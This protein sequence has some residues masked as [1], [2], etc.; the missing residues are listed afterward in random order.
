MVVEKAA[1]SY[2]VPYSRLQ[3]ILGTTQPFPLV[4]HPAKKVL[5]KESVL[6][7]E[8]ASLQAKSRH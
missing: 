3:A 1:H 2:L 8:D 4:I 5:H 7:V 6:F